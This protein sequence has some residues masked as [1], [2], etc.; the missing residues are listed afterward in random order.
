MSHKK[1]LYF[2]TPIGPIEIVHVKSIQDLPGNFTGIFQ[3][4]GFYPV[5]CVNYCYQ[6]METFC[7]AYTKIKLANILN[8]DI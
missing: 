6:D 2:D 3:E 8:S 4:S 1:Q 5:I 7:K